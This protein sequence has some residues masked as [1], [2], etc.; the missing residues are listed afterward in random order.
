[1]AHRLEFYAAPGQ[2]FYVGMRT[3]QSSAAT[4]EYGSIATAVVG[5]V[6]GVPT[7]TKIGNALAGSGFAADGTIT[8]IVPKSVFGN[9][10]PGDLLGAVNGR[11]FTGDTPETNTL[12]RSNALMDHTFAKAQ[13]DNGHPAATYTVLGNNNCEGGIVPSAV[14]R[15]N[16]GT[17]TFDIDLPLSGN[18][19][20]EC[21]S[22]GSPF[23]DHQVVVTFPGPI[24]VNTVTVS[25]GTVASSLVS[26]NQVFIN[27]TGIPNAQRITI[28]L[29]GVNDGTNI[30]NVS[31]P[32][33]VLWGD[34]NASGR[35][36]A[37]DVSLVRQQTLQTVTT[38]NF[39]EDI[40]TSNRIDAGDVS[41]ARQQALTSLP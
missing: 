26:A 21:R 30:A 19:G 20:I 37:G 32:M 24:T 6:I 35:V 8:I 17:N 36:D 14:S 1:M 38:S 27:L 13:R 29:V 11:T 34:V 31:I 10:Q 5:L 39:R 4:F 22:G 40:N 25:A 9:P 3:D 41:I 33:G 2:Q 15:K 12:E 28:T 7:E 18:I 23:G 16:H